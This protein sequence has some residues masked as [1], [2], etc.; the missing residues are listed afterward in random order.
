MHLLSDVTAA[1]FNANS[2][3]F[4]SVLMWYSKENGR[5]PAILAKLI[6][7][8]KFCIIYISRFNECVLYL[9]G[10]VVLGIMFQFDG[11]H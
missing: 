3:K 10:T 9:E 4:Q 11:H 1:V 7:K 6:C 2:G 5:Y 8:Y